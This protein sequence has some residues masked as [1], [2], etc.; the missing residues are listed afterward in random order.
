MLHF[1]SIVW[2]PISAHLTIS[3]DGSSRLENVSVSG[4]TKQEECKCV[5]ECVSMDTRTYEC[6]YWKTTCI[7]RLRENKVLK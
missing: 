6:E 2:P 5:L 7:S 3:P 4:V 1:L